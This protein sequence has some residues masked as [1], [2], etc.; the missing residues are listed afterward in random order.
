M[1]RKMHLVNDAHIKFELL[2]AQGWHIVGP[3]VGVSRM[4]YLTLS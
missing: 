3:G 1:A 2:A 4:V